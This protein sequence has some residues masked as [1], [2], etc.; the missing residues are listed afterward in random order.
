MTLLNLEAFD[1]DLG[2]V[3]VWTLS[4]I[5]LSDHRASRWR[6][7]RAG[8]KLP[9]VGGPATRAVGA[10]LLQVR[11]RSC[12]PCSGCCCL[13]ARG[14]M[15]D[16]WPWPI[17]DGLAQFYGGPFLAYRLLQL[18]LL[19]ATVLGRAGRHRAGDARL[20]GRHR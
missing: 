1:Y 4:Y 16:V 5:I 2:P 12:S 13:V 6:G 11:R 9:A 10:N 18:A 7:P 15:A 17:S 3:W 8:G 14:A 19:G 20:H